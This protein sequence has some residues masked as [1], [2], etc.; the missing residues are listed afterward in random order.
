MELSGVASVEVASVKDF[1]GSWAEY[2]V[3]E[4]G[5]MQVHHRV[6]TPEALVWSESCRTL[7]SDFGTDYVAYALGQLDDRCFTLSRR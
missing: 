6:S 2:R 5:V 7:Y 1:P 4:G 3:Y